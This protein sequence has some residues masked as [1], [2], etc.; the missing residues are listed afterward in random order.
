MSCPATYLDIQYHD[1]AITQPASTTTQGPSV[2][3][4]KHLRHIIKGLY[5]DEDHTLKDVM[6][7]MVNEHGH[8]AT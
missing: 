2:E 3:D 6:S 7:I 8:K 4:C 5:I 1:N